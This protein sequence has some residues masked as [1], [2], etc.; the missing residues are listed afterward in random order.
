MSDTLDMWHEKRAFYFKCRTLNSC[1]KI[2]HWGEKIFWF[3][4]RQSPI[5]YG[6]SLTR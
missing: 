6:P 3:L 5:G 4:D 2:G 1:G